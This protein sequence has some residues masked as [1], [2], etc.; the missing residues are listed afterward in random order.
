MRS[1]YA[2]WESAVINSDHLGDDDDGIV[3]VKPRALLLEIIKKDSLLS[4]E[5]TKCNNR[6]SHKVTH[7]LT[8]INKYQGTAEDYL[9]EYPHK[10]NEY[11]AGHLTANRP[12][13]F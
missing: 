5:S 11:F 3:L 8:D 12:I 9:K 2:C 7:G 13:C 1:N 10:F 6:P 4:E